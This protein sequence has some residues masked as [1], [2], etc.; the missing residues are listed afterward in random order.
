MAWYR[1]FRNILRPDRLQRDLQKELAFHVTE[2]AEELQSAGMSEAEADRAAHRQFGNLTAQIEWTR[3]MDIP[4]YLEAA[5]RNVRLA[6]RSLAKAPTFSLTAI[7]TLALGIGA[8]SAVFSAIDAVL[9]RPLPFPNG[10]ALLVVTQIQRKSSETNVAP[11]RLHD[12]DRMNTTLL[13]ISG[14]YSQDSSELSGELPEKLRTEFV[15]PGFLQVLGV[16]PEFGR[17]FTPQEEHAGGPDGAIISDR[18]WRRR[19]NASPDVLGKTLRLGTVSFPIVG[20]MPPSFRFPDRE[21]DI[22]IPSPLDA[23]IEQNRGLTWFTAIGRM[24]PGVTLAQARADLNTVQANL[25]R[26]FPKPDAEIS[27]RVELLRESTVGGVRRSLW[28]LFGSVSLLLLIACTNIAAL[29]MSRS[30]GRQQEIAVRFSL[31]ASRA[32]VAAQQLVEVFVLALLGAALGLLVATGASSVFRSLAHAL[33]RV[34]EIA[35]NW[36]IAAYCLVCAVATTLLSG[37]IPALRSTRRGLSQTLAQAAGRSTVSGRHPLQLALVAAQ[38]AFAVTLLSG[39]GL[40]L[41]SFQELGRVY[42]GFDPGHVLT[43][44]ISASWAETG[45]PKAGKQRINRILDG[46]ASLPGVE[47]AASSA[48]LPGLPDGYQQDVDTA[49]GGAASEP[50]L[51]AF[52]RFATPTYF[53]TVSIPLL[54]G[55][56]CRED[57]GRTL[58]MVN[59]TFANLYF[60]GTDPIGHHL[61]IPGNVYVPQGEISGITGDARENGL[62]RQP[63]PTAYWCGSSFQPGTY[64]LVRTRGDPATM[65]HAVREKLHRIEPLRPVYDVTP[66]R[67]RISDTYAENRLRTILLSCFAVTAVS[68]ACVGLYGTLSYLVSLRRREVALRLALGAQRTQVMRQFLGLGLGTAA[69]GIAAG[70][71]LATGFARLLTGMLFG[72]SASDPATL[73]GVPALVLAVSAAAA[74][75]PA[76]RAARVEPMQ[77]LREE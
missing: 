4:E 12:W 22:W 34:D 48:F 43:F 63:P 60:N 58:I 64:F 66:L 50:Q 77:A 53:A 23:P 2:R 25:A 52:V 35:L 39:A 67:D 46:L 29:L 16:A 10:D 41:R 38:I 72:V 13:G 27:P 49:E 31:G 56:M 26:E 61:S 71:L 28:I 1:K 40:L 73:T 76:V 19:F 37:M 6:V 62:D 17:D 32:S 54:A 44:H 18:L 59:R 30:T 69:T 14:Y 57:A 45:D 68:L 42:P 20:V 70:L 5:P 24:K 7:L 11:V 33:P 15:A 21:D 9:L 75:V 65:A 47:T 51:H 55:E 36:R 8:N 3:D 74:L